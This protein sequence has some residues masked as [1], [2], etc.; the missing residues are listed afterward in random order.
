MFSTIR[1]KPGLVVGLALM[2]LLSACARQI[3]PG[4]YK[5]SHVGETSTTYMGTIVSMRQV[6]VE[7]KEYLEQNGLGTVG[8]GALGGFLGSAFGKGRGRTLATVGG[9][10][11]GATAGA[12]AEKEL[13]TQMALEYVVRLDSG[14]LKTIVQGPDPVMQP[15]QR[16]YLMQSYQGRSRIVPAQ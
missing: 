6:V 3:S 11:A 1:I 12:V 5:A 7:D 14:T 9:A 2:V 10:V 15:G 16:V 13:K 8:G 4:V